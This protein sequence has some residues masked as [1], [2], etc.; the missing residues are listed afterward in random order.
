MIGFFLLYLEES[1]EVC[2]LEKRQSRYVIYNSVKG[3][4]GGQWRGC[5]GGGGGG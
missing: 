1:D 2:G 4:V 5:G 3:W